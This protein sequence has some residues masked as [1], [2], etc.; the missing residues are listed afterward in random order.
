MEKI[1]TIKSEQFADNI[2]KFENKVNDIADCLERISN[3]MSN[4]DGT[5]DIWKS[6]NAELVRDDYKELEQQF[7]KINVE[8]CAYTIFLKDTLAK[9]EDTESKIDKK[10]DD[11]SPDLDVNE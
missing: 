9:Y 4:I 1:I 10:V 2:Q 8:L 3:Q 11:N 5:N 6:K 7:Q